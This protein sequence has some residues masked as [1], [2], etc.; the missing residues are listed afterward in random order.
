MPGAKIDMIKLTSKAKSLFNYSNRIFLI[1]VLGVLLA[2][3]LWLHF[4]FGAG[5]ILWNSL[6]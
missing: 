3:V 4:S 6:F 2:F 1:L 5:E